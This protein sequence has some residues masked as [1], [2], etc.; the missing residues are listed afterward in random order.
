MIFAFYRMVT[1]NGA[2]DKVTSGR[3]SILYALI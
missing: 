2:E 1:A 3:M